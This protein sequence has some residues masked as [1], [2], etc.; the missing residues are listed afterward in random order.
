MALV[1]HCV[2]LASPSCGTDRRS[3]S[4]ATS[5]IGR[6]RRS[7]SKMDLYRIPCR[8]SPR[9]LCLLLPLPEGA[10]L[11]EVDHVLLECCKNSLRGKPGSGFC[12]TLCLAVI[13]ER[14][15]LHSVGLSF[16]LEQGRPRLLLVWEIQDM[17]YGRIWWALL[18]CWMCVYIY[19]HIYL[20]SKTC[21]FSS[22]F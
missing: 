1:P 14:Y 17:D 15:E 10:L 22:E 9:L 2:G 5:E 18:S 20:S 8:R 16:K 4:I 3:A 12:R 21:L 13:A 7:C 11:I 19:I 6:V